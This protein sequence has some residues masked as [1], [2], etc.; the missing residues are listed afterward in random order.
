MTIIDISRL[1]HPAMAVWP[2]DEPYTIVQELKLEEGA[3]VNLT[4]LHMSAHTGTH[5]DAPLHYAVEQPGVDALDLS[6]YWGLAQVVSTKKRGGPLFPEDFGGVD[7]SLAP[8]LLIKSLASE[9]DQT[10]F[11]SI[12]VYPSPQLADEL[13][14][15]GVILLGTDGPSMD[16]VDSKTLAGHKAL[17]RN[18][19]KILEWLDLS[20]VSE[21]LYELSALPLKIATGDG[22]PVRAALR[23]VGR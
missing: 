11:P 21:G 20:G 16:A 7:L 15:Q 10:V 13:G 18:D 1:L 2:G 19:I 14:R 22:S 12:Y 9:M 17:L 23:P 6:I 3:S 5:I 8:R 4:K